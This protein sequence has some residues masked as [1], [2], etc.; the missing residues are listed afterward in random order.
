VI[1]V[2]FR[3]GRGSG[4][5]VKNRLLRAFNENSTQNAPQA[6]AGVVIGGDFR[7]GR[8]SGGKV[9]NRLLRAFNENS[10]KERRASTGELPPV[11]AFL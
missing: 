8:G 4:G 1:G 5:K 6:S 10:A 2:D 3:R 7:R 9:K 11:S